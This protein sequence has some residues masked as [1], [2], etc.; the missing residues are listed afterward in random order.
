MTT[1]YHQC[2]SLRARVVIT[3]PMIKRL[4][5]RTARVFRPPRIG[6][7]K[8]VC[9]AAVEKPDVKDPLPPSNRTI[10]K[11]GDDELEISRVLGGTWQVSGGWGAVDPKTAVNAML[12]H[13]DGG[14]TT[15]D[16]ADIYGPAE[17]LYGA[18]MDRARRERGEEYA[19]GIQGCTKWV[20]R[21]GRMTRQVVEAAVDRSRKRMDVSCL[22]MLQFH[23]WD[24]SDAGYLDALKHLTDLKEAG[25]IRTLALTNFDTQRLQII[26][27]NGIPI[28]SN[29]VQ[30]SMVD[31]RPQQQMRELCAL[32]GVKLLTY[33]ALLGGLLSKKFLDAPEP[34]KW[35]GPALA[36]PSQ[37]KY[38]QMIDAWG[39]WR[40]F[41]DLL[42]ECNAIA[43][44]HGVAI[45]TVGLRFILD[46]DNVGGTMMGVRFGLSEHIRDTQ[47]VFKFE[48][49]EEDRS[50]IKS[51]I[52]KGKDLQS[53]IG[54]CG[55]EYR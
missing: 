16:L 4:T 7:A 38:K 18:L 8:Q 53:I 51:V 9:A 24:Y 54:D 49:D 34:G 46:Q 52:S 39:G 13:V 40:L 55:D 22:D 17:D 26:L 47:A 12:Q 43:R 6:C 36:N 42:R 3:S 23:W 50:R 2:T 44:K 27:G 33:G 11:Q 21:P 5:F 14:I 20:P 19:A 31:M 29:Q 45:S 15:F 48:L 32:T 1:M 10:M 25:K 37:K 28:V 35:G 41:Q 30:H